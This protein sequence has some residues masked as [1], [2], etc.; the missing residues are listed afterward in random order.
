[1]RVRA[2][3][4]TFLLI[5]DQRVAGAL[6]LPRGRRLGTGAS[7]HPPSARFRLDTH[8][9]ILRQLIDQLRAGRLGGRFAK[10]VPDTGHVLNAHRTA[11]GW[12]AKAWDWADRR[13]GGVAR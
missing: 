5:A 7:A 13:V 12:F 8:Q 10:V 4:A 3:V 6:C 9:I 2:A 1:M 11:S